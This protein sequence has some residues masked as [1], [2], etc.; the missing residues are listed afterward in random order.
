[1]TSSTGNRNLA[2]PFTEKEFAV[3]WENVKREYPF[4]AMRYLEAL[5]IILDERPKLH[6]AS[7]DIVAT[8]GVCDPLSPTYLGD[9]IC[10]FLHPGGG[11]PPKI[12][13]DRPCKRPLN[14]GEIGD[15]LS[16]LEK[17]F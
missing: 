2:Q 8:F 14:S 13:P 7:S 16:C 3:Q 5:H 4:V 17:T 15:Y 9:A 11:V 6:L 12:T 1:M 10:A